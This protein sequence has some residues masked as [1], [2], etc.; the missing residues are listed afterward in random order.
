MSEILG[1]AYWRDEVI[2]WQDKLEQMIFPLNDMGFVARSLFVNNLNKARSNV[3]ILEN[4]FTRGDF[5]KK[6]V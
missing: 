5:V 3:R 2:H 1:L 4:A 6:E